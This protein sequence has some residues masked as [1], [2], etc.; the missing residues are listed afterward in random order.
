M[1]ECASTKN[2]TKCG[3]CVFVL[4]RQALEASRE[5]ALNYDGSASGLTIY[6]YVN[7]SPLMLTDPM[8]LMGGSGG[9]RPPPREPP[10]AE[11]QCPTPCEK[12]QADYIRD[13]Y[14]D[15]TANFA[16]PNFSAYSY[17]PGSPN[18]G[19]AWTSA[20]ISGGAKA[21]IAGGAIVGGEAMMASS[22][23]W[24]AGYGIATGAAATAVAATAAGTGAFAFATTAETMAKAACW[25]KCH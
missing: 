6:L 16:V 25:A 20:A 11:M 15:I 13:N 3:R 5:N 7:G 22:A 8:G 21:A 10:A 23:T 4:D 12:C 9:R 17:L 1:A 18:F 24:A 2:F 14:G 19:R